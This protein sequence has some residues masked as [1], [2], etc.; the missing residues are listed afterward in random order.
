MTEQADAKTA[1][2]NLFERYSNYL[3]V[4]TVVA[5]GWI[6]SNGVTFTSF[7]MKSAALWSLGVS[8]VFGIFTLALLPLIAEQARD[9]ESIFM[10]PVKF[11]LFGIRCTLYLPQTCRPQHALFILGIIFYCIGNARFSWIGIVF[12][13]IAIVYGL[14]S[15]PRRSRR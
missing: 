10:V 8:I 1:A 11:T 12:G 15:M 14:F 3:L 6:A 2:L 9:E 4:T 13:S 7:V 5:A